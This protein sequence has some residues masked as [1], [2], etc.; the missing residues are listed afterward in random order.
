MIV[1]C[2]VCGTIFE[3]EDGFISDRLC[4]DCE[5]DTITRA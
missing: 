3:S 5:L 2:V 1:K 4:V